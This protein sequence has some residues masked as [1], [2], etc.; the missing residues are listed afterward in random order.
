MLAFKLTEFLQLQF[1]RAVN[2]TDVGSIVALPAV[3]ALKPNIFPFAFFCHTTLLCRL[4]IV[5]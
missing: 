3:L 2:Y 5:H 1:G 4:L